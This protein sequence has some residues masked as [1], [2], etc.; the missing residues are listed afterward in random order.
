MAHIATYNT[1]V[2]CEH[3]IYSIT[4]EY[5]K[6]EQYKVTYPEILLKCVHITQ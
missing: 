2:E 6:M 1:R 3:I 4:T 5:H